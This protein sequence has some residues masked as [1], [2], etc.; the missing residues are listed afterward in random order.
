MTTEHEVA[1]SPSQLTAAT[2]E[3]PP[4]FARWAAS[5]LAKVPVS[6]PTLVFS[7]TSVVTGVG[8]VSLEA[9][10]RLTLASS[11]VATIPAGKAS[12]NVGTADLD[13][14]QASIA[15]A[16]LQSDVPGLYVRTAVLTGRSLKISLNKEAPQAVTVGWF[17]LG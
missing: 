5:L 9:Q 4:W 8:N 3:P 17:V 12:V 13:V 1:P 16:T 14:R 15:S 7:P 6:M 10:R 11:G 2:A